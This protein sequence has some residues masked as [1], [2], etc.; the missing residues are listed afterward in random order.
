MLG[1]IMNII[2]YYRDNIALCH[3]MIAKNY[4]VI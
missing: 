4:T 2:I 3:D 1:K